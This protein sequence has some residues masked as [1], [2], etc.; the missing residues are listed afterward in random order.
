MKDLG[1]TV[2]EID[3]MDIDDLKVDFLSL[4]NTVVT[5]YGDDKEVEGT[6]EK[7]TISAK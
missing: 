2:D 4:M 6:Q 7:E 5:A 3:N 1:I